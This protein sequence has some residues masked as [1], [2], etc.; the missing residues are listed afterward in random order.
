MTSATEIHHIKFQ[1][2]EIE[3]INVLPLLIVADDGCCVFEKEIDGDSVLA[4][5]CQIDFLAFLE[6]I[7]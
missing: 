3:A 4:T 1:R 2:N 7:L 6:K 5:G